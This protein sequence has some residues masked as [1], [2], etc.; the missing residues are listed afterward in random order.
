LGSIRIYTLQQRNK[1]E[2][3][4]FKNSREVRSKIGGRGKAAVTTSVVES[5]PKPKLE[6]AKVF[7]SLFPTAGAA[8]LDFFLI[9]RGYD[10][11]EAELAR[12]THLTHKT[13]SK[14]LVNLTNEDILKI[15]RIVG[16]SKMY[17]LNSDSPKTKILIQYSD[18][19]IKKAYENLKT[20]T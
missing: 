17:A 2:N 15:T 18:M 10:Y 14:E 13:I 8:L 4:K 5:E 11:T 20:T 16:R 6:H 9:F 19:V 12:R 1:H 3:Q 7:K